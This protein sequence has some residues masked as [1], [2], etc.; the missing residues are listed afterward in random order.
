M[1]WGMSTYAGYISSQRK[2][3]MLERQTMAWV[4][5]CGRIWKKGEPAP[6]IH[7]KC[8]QRSRYT[9]PYHGNQTV[10]YIWCDEP[11]SICVNASETTS[12]YDQFVNSIQGLGKVTNAMYE[13]KAR[14]SGHKMD[15]TKQK[16]LGT[17]IVA[18]KPCQKDNAILADF[19]ANY[20]FTHWHHTIVSHPHP[21]RRSSIVHHLF[22]N[23]LSCF[24]CIGHHL[25]MLW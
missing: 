1:E 19:G 15:K 24:F 22:L 20:D 2:S 9:K 4:C 16:N 14:M 12:R 5:L 6:L 7:G 8:W 23:Y 3:C 25:D 11:L 17:N 10:P 21:K 18:T 13:L